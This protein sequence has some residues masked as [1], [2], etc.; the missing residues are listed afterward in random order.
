MNKI[1]ARIPVIGHLFLPVHPTPEDVRVFWNYMSQRFGFKIV[2]KATA[3]DMKL[4]AGLLDALNIVHKDDFMER[5]TTTVAGTVY[6]PFDLGVPNSYYGLWEQMVVCVHEAQHIVQDDKGL[7]FEWDYL[8]STAARTQYEVE[9]YR[10]G[11]EM[12][13]RYQGIMPSVGR[14]ASTLTFYGCTSDDVKAATAALNAAVPMI[15]QGGLSTKASVAAAT[16]M[17]RRYR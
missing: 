9:A 14:T 5:F 4:I 10:A 17:D 8:T 7:K 1:L 11:M 3:L 6:I 12:W 13:W 15:R 16:W 2:S